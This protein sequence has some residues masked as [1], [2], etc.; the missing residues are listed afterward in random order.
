MKKIL[1]LF[2]IV[3]LA[4]NSNKNDET[5]PVYRGQK[6][7]VIRETNEDDSLQ[8]NGHADSLNSDSLMHVKKKGNIPNPGNPDRK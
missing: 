8:M 5:G 6:G 2:P 7:V 3:L 1:F 4:C